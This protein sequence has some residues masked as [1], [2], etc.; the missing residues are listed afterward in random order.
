MINK[1]EC[2]DKLVERVSKNYNIFCSNVPYDNGFIDLV[3][4][5]PSDDKCDVYLI[6]GVTHATA[7]KFWRTELFI[8]K[9]DYPKEIHDCYLYACYEDKLFFYEHGLKR[10]ILMSDGKYN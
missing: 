1:K 8:I 10:L 9:C 6:T 4:K 2:L 3:A 5:R 7:L